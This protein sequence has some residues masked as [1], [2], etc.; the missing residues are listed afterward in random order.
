MTG[1]RSA[2]QV[3]RAA[4]EWLAANAATR[5]GGPQLA[6]DRLSFELVLQ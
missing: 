6:L 1:P 3:E 4:R 2:D 5:T